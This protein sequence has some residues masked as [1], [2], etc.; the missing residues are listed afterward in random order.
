MD[1]LEAEDGRGGQG[2]ESEEAAAPANNTH[3]TLLHNTTKI[4]TKSTLFLN[5]FCCVFV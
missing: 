1:I 5:K 3:T 4:F 2:E